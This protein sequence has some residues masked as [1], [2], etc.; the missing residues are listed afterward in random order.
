MSGPFL[1]EGNAVPLFAAVSPSFTDLRLIYSRHQVQ[2]VV[3]VSYMEFPLPS[4]VLGV[5][6]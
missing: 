2:M 1:S 4:V 6:K 3:L 5:L